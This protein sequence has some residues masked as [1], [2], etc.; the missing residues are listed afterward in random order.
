MCIK[1]YVIM[2]SSSYDSKK[3]F[4]A[5]NLGNGIDGRFMICSVIYF[6]LWNWNN[7]FRLH[8]EPTY[9]KT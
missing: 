4:C 5:E 1:H 7:S 9:L 3:Y 6:P 2:L 8:R